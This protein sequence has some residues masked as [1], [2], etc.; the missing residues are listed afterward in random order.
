MSKV[1]L[2]FVTFLLDFESTCVFD[3]DTLW[4]PMWNKPYIRGAGE[5]IPQAIMLKRKQITVDFGHDLRGLSTSQKARS[6]SRSPSR[7]MGTATADSPA[8]SRFGL[9]ETEPGPGVS[10]RY[11][12]SFEREGDDVAYVGAES[13]RDTEEAKESQPDVADR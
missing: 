9:G 13:V 2:T 1:S 7:R 6:P 11:D 5:A 12:D 3:S 8:R 10:N 4:Y